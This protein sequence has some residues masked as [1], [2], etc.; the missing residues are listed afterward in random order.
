[1]YFF[2]FKPAESQAYEDQSSSRMATPPSEIDI[3]EWEGLGRGALESGR[4]S[5][6]V[7]ELL[8]KTKNRL[9]RL[10]LMESHGPNMEDSVHDFHKHSKVGR[11]IYGREDEHSDQDISDASIHRPESERSLAGTVRWVHKVRGRIS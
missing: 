4:E 5:S 9:A 10:E 11:G 8:E 6:D 2:P 1:M 7:D 3:K